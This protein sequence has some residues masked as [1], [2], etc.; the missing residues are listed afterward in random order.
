MGKFLLAAVASAVVGL[1]LWQLFLTYC[2]DYM[3]VHIPVTR[4]LLEHGVKGTWLYVVL[5][6][7]DTVLNV[8][9]SLPAAFAL[10]CL[11]P[12]KR[13]A[14]LAIAVLTGFIWENRL[15]FEQPALPPVGV[16]IFVYGIFATL[17][18]LPLA[19]VVLDVLSGYVRRWRE[20]SP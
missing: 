20:A 16:G 13:L 7:H 15:L 3:A 5:I 18:M 4:W 17:A 11:R 6:I 2:W 12:R 9:L 10:R 1:V 19:T 14:Y 8:L